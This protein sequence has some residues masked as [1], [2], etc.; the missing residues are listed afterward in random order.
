[1]RNLKLLGI[2]LFF[3]GKEK[4]EEIVA[5]LIKKGEISEPEGK[6]LVEDLV[7][8]SKAASK[9][10]EERI[11]KVVSDVHE[12]LH[13]PMK[14]EIAVQ[15]KRIEKLEKAGTRKSVKSPKKISKAAR[16]PRT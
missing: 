8:K 14:K 11:R 16:K 13:A 12:K 5:E 3:T 2:G 10:L 6:E 1:M 15:K 4:I 7:A 9:E